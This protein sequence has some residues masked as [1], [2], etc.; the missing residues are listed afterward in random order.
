MK[1]LFVLLMFMSLFIA[2]SSCSKKQEQAQTKEQA[3]TEHMIAK[4]SIT[5]DMLDY[6]FCGCGMDF[7]KANMHIADTVHYHGKVLGFCSDQCKQAFEK[8]PDG[9]IAKI[10][11][12]GKMKKME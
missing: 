4:D 10:E 12:K 6:K 11:E 7:T 8:D 9:Y 3:P 1:K 5:A 2:L